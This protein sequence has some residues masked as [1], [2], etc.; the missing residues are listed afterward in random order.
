MVRTH[1][2]L[3]PWKSAQ[4]WVLVHE[5]LLTSRTVVG[6]CVHVLPPSCVV[7][8]VVWGSAPKP[9]TH[10]P[11]PLQATPVTTAAGTPVISIGVDQVMPPSFEVKSRGAELVA[12]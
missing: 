1:D 9:M 10:E 7:H 11:K 4:H 5:K 12:S 6:S 8:K 2:W 3:E